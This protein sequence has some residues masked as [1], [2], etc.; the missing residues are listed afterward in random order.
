MKGVTPYQFEILQHVAAG[1]D[2]GPLDFDQLLDLLSWMP[3]K[4]SSQFTIR[5]VMKKGLLTK[6]DLTFR[7]G[8]RRVLYTLTPEGRLALDPRG[9]SAPEVEDS[10]PGELSSVP[11]HEWVEEMED[12]GEEK[13]V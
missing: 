11:G 10:L 3:S 8:R 4:A 2:D 1:G 12:L 9:A 5:A 6:G 7:R 13:T